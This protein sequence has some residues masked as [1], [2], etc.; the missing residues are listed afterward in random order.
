MLI[1]SKVSLIVLWKNIVQ[2]QHLVKTDL[3]SGLW[4]RK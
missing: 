4:K 2:T 3:N 1:S